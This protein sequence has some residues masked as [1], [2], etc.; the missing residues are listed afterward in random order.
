MNDY[1]SSEEN[2]IKTIQYLESF[3]KNI[4]DNELNEYIKKV[5]SQSVAK[6]YL[7]KDIPSPNL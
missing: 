1:V 2:I 3:C 6:Q 5:K 4:I 7:E